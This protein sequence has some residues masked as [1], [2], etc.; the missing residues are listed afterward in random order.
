MPADN[1]HKAPADGD[2]LSVPTHPPPLN[3]SFMNSSRQMGRAYLRGGRLGIYVLKSLFLTLTILA[4]RFLH[5]KF[6]LWHRIFF[7][8][9]DLS[10]PQLLP[11]IRTQPV[12]RRGRAQ[13]GGG[14]GAGARHGGCTGTHCPPFRDPGRA[15]GWP[16]PPTAPAPPTPPARAG[17]PT[18]LGARL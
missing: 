6:C 12:P 16:N 17:Q 4:E 9:A 5:N 8:S 11:G 1:E 13:P 10:H 3:L 14:H 2:A 7:L 15:L 18:V